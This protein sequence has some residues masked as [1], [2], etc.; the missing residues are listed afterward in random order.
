MMAGG[1]EGELQG[2]GAGRRSRGDSV[3]CAQGGAGER[4]R[5]R[6]RVLS[7]RGGTERERESV[8][9]QGRDSE[10]EGECERT[11]KMGDESPGDMRRMEM[12]EMVGGL[13]ALERSDPGASV[14]VESDDG[15]GVMG[16]CVR[17]AS[18]I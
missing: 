13:C 4:Q 6:W 11:G 17:G 12:R 10:G 14:C 9:L 7:C 1:K 18:E 3:V 5:G 2:G 8:E 15:D 16:F